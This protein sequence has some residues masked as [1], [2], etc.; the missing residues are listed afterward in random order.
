MYKKVS[1]RVIQN[2][3]EKIDE[4]FFYSMYDKYH[5]SWFNLSKIISND[6]LF[7]NFISRKISEYAKNKKIIKKENPYLNEYDIEIEL[8]ARDKL[9]K[10]ITKELINHFE[11]KKANKEIDSYKL[12]IPAEYSNFENNPAFKFE[13]DAEA[14]KNL[15]IDFKI[16]EIMNKET[17]ESVYEYIFVPC[18]EVISNNQEKAKEII[19]E[20]IILIFKGIVYTLNNT[21]ILKMKIKKENQEDQELI[22]FPDKAELLKAGNEIEKIIV[23]DINLILQAM[24]EK[25]SMTALHNSGLMNR[26]IEKLDSLTIKLS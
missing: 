17:E 26:M 11:N 9:K 12:K 5:F 25:K 18:L 23:S 2:T 6:L 16:K 21:P 4:R 22:L 10:I 3:L 7:F 19:E 8:T 14:I 15:D 13:K 20:A 1:K 24:F